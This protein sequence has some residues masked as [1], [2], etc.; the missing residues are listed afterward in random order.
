MWHMD[1]YIYSWLVSS[2]FK[3][4]DI[5]Q[6]KLTSHRSSTFRDARLGG[7]VESVGSG[8]GGSVQRLVKLRQRQSKKSFNLGKDWTKNGPKTC[9]DV[10]NRWKSDE[11]KD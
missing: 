8:V 5:L 6:D 4:V 10:E 11:K 3:S 2:D 7:D 9:G 1:I